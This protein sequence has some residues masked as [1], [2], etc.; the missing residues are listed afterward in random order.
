L[1]RSRFFNAS[2]FLDFAVFAVRSPTGKDIFVIAG[3][4]PRRLDL[5]MVRLSMCDIEQ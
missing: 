2:D 4:A 5:T 1:L 3:I